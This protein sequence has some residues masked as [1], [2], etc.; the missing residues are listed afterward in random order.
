MPNRPA[1]IE[2][3]FE[4]NPKS[5]IT[6][7]KDGKKINFSEHDLVKI[8]EDGRVLQFLKVHSKNK[9]LYTCVVENPVGKTEKKF[10]IDVFGKYSCMQFVDIKCMHIYMFTELEI[11]QIVKYSEYFKFLHL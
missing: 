5:F 6:W 8:F 9:G 2:C 7:Y 10:K 11:Y 3:R 4:S 1:E